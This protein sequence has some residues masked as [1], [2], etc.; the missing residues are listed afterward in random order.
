MRG[1]EQ[2]IKSRIAGLKPPFVFVND[3]PC[4][5]DWFEY[6]DHA[7]VCTH[8]DSL[9]NIDFRFLMGCKVSISAESEARAKELFKRIKDAGATTVAACT[10]EP[11]EH[12]L[13]QAGWAEVWRAA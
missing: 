8:M 5:T 3:Y 7:T 4:K 13:N 11:L 12:A 2:I 6:R 10:I 1:H 9:S